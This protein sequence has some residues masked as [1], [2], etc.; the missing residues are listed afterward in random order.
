MK[1]ML[2]MFIFIQIVLVSYVPS[3][4]AKFGQTCAQLP[5]KGSNDYLVNDTAYGFI[6]KNIDM[7]SYIKDACSSEGDQFK[8]CIRNK[9]DDKDVCST[10]TMNAGDSKTLKSLTKNADIIGKDFIADIVLSVKPIN[11]K[12]CLTMPTSRG[13]TPLFCRDYKTKPPE[14]TPMKEICKS[15]GQSCYDGRSKSQ[16]LLSFSGLTINCL[17]ETLNKVFYTGNDCPELDNNF[18]QNLRPFPDFL[19][20]MKNTI[21]AALILYVM[22]YGFKLVMNQEYV[23]LNKI[24]TFIITFIFVLYFSVGISSGNSNDANKVKH[25]GMT[26]FALPILVEITSN[27]TEMVFLSGG[28][29]GLCNFDRAKYESGYEFYKVWDAID[30]RVGYYLGMQALANV[31]SMFGSLKGTTNSNSGDPISSINSNNDVPDSLSTPGVFSLFTVIFGLFLAGNIIVVI[32]SIVFVVVFVS[33]ILYFI[34]AYLV[35]MVTLYGMAYVSPIFIPMILF[36][37]TKG[38]FDSWLRIVISCALQPAIIGCFIALLLTMYD[39]AIYG[40]C[41]FQ[42]HDYSWGDSSFSTF[43]LRLPTNDVEKCTSSAGY[44]LGQ[45]YQ[46]GGWE[47]TSFMLFQAYQVKDFLNLSLSLLYVMI[48]VVIFYHFIQYANEFASDLTGGPS[49]ASVTVSPT[50]VMDKMSNAAS[51]AK[52]AASGKAKNP[53]QGGGGGGASDK[54]STGGGGGAADKVSTG[55]GGIG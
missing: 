19:I 55:R 51:A 10:V 49:M 47:K 28:S 36:E 31:G 40:N 35:A 22:I 41:E 30:C 5:L 33:T 23:E 1:I 52:N 16:S 18:S 44:K 12:L 21:R 38:Y 54:A 11:S 26:E 42:R 15:L 24:S 34:T 46:G 2:R 6:Q 25:N 8:F 32:S 3:V 4:Y 20:A 50:M 7:T 43:E 48:F 53:A 37:R 27:L 45:Y 39:S 17:R 13:A 9:A 14:T 29:Q